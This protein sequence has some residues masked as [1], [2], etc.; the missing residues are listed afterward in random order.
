[1]NFFGYLTEAIQYVAYK[2]VHNRV[3]NLKKN[4]FHVSG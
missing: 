2:A 4:Y 3:I 1:M